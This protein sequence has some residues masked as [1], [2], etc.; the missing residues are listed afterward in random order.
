MREARPSWILFDGECGL[1]DAVVVWVLRHDREGS[2]RYGALQGAA[3]A[4]VRA[5]HPGL[6]SPDETMMLVE[7]P[8]TPAER[9][10]TRS[11]A[12]LAIVAGLGGAWRL[13]AA[14]RLVPRPIR[15]AL[16]GFVAR[17]RRR[18]FGRRDACRVPTAGERELFL[19]LSG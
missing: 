9:V 18:W 6:P 2:F 8:E 14:L 10:R 4:R 15:D 19:D 7:S 16:Y 5:R 11:D 13:V 17:R 12:A 3:A 1:C